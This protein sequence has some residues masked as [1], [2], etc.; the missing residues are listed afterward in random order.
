MDELRSR[1]QGFT[2]LELLVGMLIMSILVA[3]ASMYYLHQRRKGWE[4]QVHASVRHMAGAENNFLYGAGAPAFTSDLDDL[5]LTGFRW[6]EESV[7]PYVALATR[8]TYCIQVH[9]TRDPSIVWHL[10]STV[11]RPERGPAT[12]AECGDPEV[13]GTYIAGLPDASYGRDGVPSSVAA[14]VVATNDPMTAGAG[15]TR[16][17]GDATEGGGGTSSQTPIGTTPQDEASSGEYVSSEPSDG[18]GS[19]GSSSGTTTDGGNTSSGTTTGGGSSGSG[20]TDQG[21]GAEGSTTGC[22]GGTSGGGST[23]G[24]NHPSGSDRDDENG[25]SGEQGTSGSDPDGDENDGADKPGQDG[26][27][28]SG[29]QDGNNGSGNDT[30]FE[31]DNEGPDRDGTPTPGTTC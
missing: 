4:A 11:G 1:E 17:G 6:D 23:T 3:T 26:G 27:A 9:S 24:T 12:P 2:L 5:Y 16:N 8:E 14:G 22:E 10:S 7:R 19:S 30:D 28:N 29:D 13:L 20:T 31:D 15:S 21:S 25:G 18:S